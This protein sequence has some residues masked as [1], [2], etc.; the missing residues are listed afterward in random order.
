MN[1]KDILK[2]EMKSIHDLNLSKRIGEVCECPVCGNSFV[3]KHIKHVYCGGRDDQT[4][5]NAYNNFIRYNTVY[6]FGRFVELK[7]KN[8]NF[9]NN[10]YKK[11][12]KPFNKYMSFLFG[13]DSSLSD[14]LNK[15]LNETKERH[16]HVSETLGKIVDV[17]DKDS[18]KCNEYVNKQTLKNIESSIETRI[19]TKLEKEFETKYKDKLEEEYNKGYNRACDNYEEAK[20]WENA[21][22]NGCV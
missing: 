19:R 7:K 17:L 5:K 21:Q 3:K 16:K 15:D 4:C 8:N 22:F 14:K 1:K 13:N 18:K 10:S 12:S 6:D 11:S 9:S 2:E 20:Q